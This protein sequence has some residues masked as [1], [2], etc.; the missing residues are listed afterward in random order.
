[1]KSKG[2]QKA[3]VICG[4]TI[5]GL[6]P[7]RDGSARERIVFESFGLLLVGMGQDEEYLDT[8]DGP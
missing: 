1:M 4:Q 6:E 7:T 3:F 5:G 2:F 8:P